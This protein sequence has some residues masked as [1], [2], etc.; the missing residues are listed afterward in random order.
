MTRLPSPP[1]VS[2]LSKAQY[3]GW[4]C[5]WCNASLMNVRSTVSAGISR[6]NSGA[7]VLDSEVFACGPNCPSMHRRSDEV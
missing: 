7:H 1:P 6:G 3:A 5:C 4:N 2:Q